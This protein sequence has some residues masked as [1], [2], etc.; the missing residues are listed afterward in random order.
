MKILPEYDFEYEIT[1]LNSPVIP[2]YAWFYDS[3]LN[4]FLMR[5]ITMLEETVGPTVTTKINNEIVKIPASWHILIVDDDTK[6][7]DTV[8]I[9]QCANSA[10]KAFAMHPR[11]N[12]YEPMSIQLLDIDYTGAVVHLTIPKANHICHPIGK[13]FASKNMPMNI[14]IGPQDIGKNMVNMSAQELLM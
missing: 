1:S 6:T 5:P 7:V 12:R 8:L 14:I 3:K 11:L 4:D 2:E 13:T 9:T 10:F